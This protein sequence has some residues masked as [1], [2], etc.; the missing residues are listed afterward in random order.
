MSDVRKEVVGI[1]E[2]YS[3][4]CSE[5]DCHAQGEML[6]WCQDYTTDLNETISQI[7]EGAYT[8]TEIVKILE[9]KKAMG[10]PTLYRK[11]EDEERE[12]DTNNA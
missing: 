5:M 10:Y 11:A 4:K 1:L 2:R 7:R 6:K 9:E 8:L 12:N 3:R